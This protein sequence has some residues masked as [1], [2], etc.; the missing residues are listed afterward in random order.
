MNATEG[1]EK[2]ISDFVDKVFTRIIQTYTYTDDMRQFVSHIA[3]GDYV[4]LVEYSRENSKALTGF[5]NAI[6]VAYVE[7]YRSNDL[8]SEADH[9][10]QKMIFTM[11]QFGEAIRTG[12]AM[13]DVKKIEATFKLFERRLQGTANL[14]PHNRHAVVNENDESA[15]TSLTELLKDFNFKAQARITEPL[16]QKPQD[17][18]NKTAPRSS[19]KNGSDNAIQVIS[20]PDA[21]APEVVREMTEVEK[22]IAQRDQSTPVPKEREENVRTPADVRVKLFTRYEEKEIAFLIDDVF[23]LLSKNGMEVVVKFVAS[24]AAGDYHKLANLCGDDP[25]ALKSFVDAVEAIHEKRRQTFSLSEN[26]DQYIKE[27]ISSA[28]GVEKQ[29]SEKKLN[30]KIAVDPAVF[31]ELFKLFEHRILSVMNELAYAGGS[32]GNLGTAVR[33]PHEFFKGFNDQT[34]ALILST[35]NRAQENLRDD[36][37]SNP[38]GKVASAAEAVV[39]SSVPAQASAG[40]LQNRQYQIIDSVYIGQDFIRTQ[41]YL[42]PPRD[43]HPYLKWLLYTRNL[44]PGMVE[45]YLETRTKVVEIYRQAKEGNRNIRYRGRVY[46]AFLPFAEGSAGNY[47]L[48]KPV[49]QS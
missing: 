15:I 31:R 39:V 40:E 35:F 9:Y 8:D 7:M 30:E 48:V 13:P 33:S 12:G 11:K 29:I 5:I 20:E 43:L 6:D 17:S 16:A 47:E 22:Y 25:A 21:E 38:F 18:L 4:R 3:D 34:Q 27:W 10:V 1:D 36:I 23:A 14:R 26:G 45:S 32:L 24:I 46:G 2:L 42:N 37:L 44:T 41:R 28:R 19:E 49:P